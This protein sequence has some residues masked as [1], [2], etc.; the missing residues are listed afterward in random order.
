[1]IAARATAVV[2]VLAG[3]AGLSA[4]ESTA[5]KSAAIAR[6]GK[7]AVQ[8]AGTLRISRN[9]DLAVA[10]AVVVRGAG[11]TVA[12]AVE[13]R[14]RGGHAQRDV[15]VL[16]DV[17]DAEGGSLYKNDATGLQP[18]LQRLASVRAHR[19]SWWVNDQVTVA[20]APR[21]VK[22]RVGA[23]PA[24]GSVPD[25]SLRGVHFDGDATGRYLTGVVVNPSRIVLRA[26][27][28]FAVALKGSRVVAAGRA[29]VP[30]LPA[31]GGRKQIHFRLFFVGDPRG[32]RVALTVA[33]TVVASKS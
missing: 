19:T 29:L 22:A 9:A 8:D 21:S 26:V 7:E 25:V 18:A 30:K 3:A 32:A 10:R 11:G 2:V 31:A 13:V 15:P 1:M 24:A 12:A 23:A 28:I 16:I 14:N 17:R 33:P 20:S 27:P 6:E 5:D 4:C